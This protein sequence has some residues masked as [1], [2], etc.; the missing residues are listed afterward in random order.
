MAACPWGEAQIVVEDVTQGSAYAC[1]LLDHL[2][3]D[4]DAGGGSNE[5][6]YRCLAGL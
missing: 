5:R 4:H 2:G 3:G 1:H 6:Q